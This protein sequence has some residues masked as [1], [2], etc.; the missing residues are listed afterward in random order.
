MSPKQI[1]PGQMQSCP[2]TC[3]N[4]SSF[5]F[6][7]LQKFLS[8]QSSLIVFSSFAPESWPPSLK[9]RETREKKVSVISLLVTTAPRPDSA[10]LNPEGEGWK[11]KKREREWGW[12]TDECERVCFLLEN[13]KSFTLNVCFPCRRWLKESS[14]MEFVEYWPINGKKLWVKI[15][16]KSG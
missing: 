14:K 8:L 15:A 5:I 4:F 3:N 10:F 2:S 13:R 11:S 7:S 16:V 6:L 9:I 12:R 1:T